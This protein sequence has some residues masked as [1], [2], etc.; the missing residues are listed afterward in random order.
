MPKYNFQPIDILYQS[1]YYYLNH[2]YGV[3]RKAL[4]LLKPNIYTNV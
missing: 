1:I 4:K 2:P 3:K